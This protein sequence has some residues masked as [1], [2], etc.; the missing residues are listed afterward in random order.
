MKK[1]SLIILVSALLVG[2]SSAISCNVNSLSN[3]G[4][5]KDSGNT[6]K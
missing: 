4:D 5:V 6:N 3:L 1:L 2:V